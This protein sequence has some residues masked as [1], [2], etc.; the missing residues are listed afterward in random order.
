M[1]RALPSVLQAGVPVFKTA[2]AAG[3]CLND[4]LVQ[5]L[6]SLMTVVEDTTILHRHDEATLRQVQQ[7]SRQILSLGGMLTDEGKAAVYRLDQEF[8]ARRI[9]PG[10]SAD[11]LAAT[12]FLW[13]AENSK[14]N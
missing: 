7:T 8:I 12:Y 10:G 13:L 5:A 2:L 11:L 3:C 14:S 6:L 4:A 1:E 9:S